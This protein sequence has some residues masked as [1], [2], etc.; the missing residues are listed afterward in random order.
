ML[1]SLAYGYKGCSHKFK[2]AP[3]EKFF[4]NN[5]QARNV[6]KAGGKVVKLIGYEFREERRWAKAKLEDDKYLY[7]FPLVEWEWSR[8]ECIAAINRMGIPL[9]GKSSCFFCPASTK[10]EIDQLK[11]QYPVLFQRALSLEDNAK[12]NLTSVKGLGRR[13]SWRDYATTSEV[14]DV[15]PCMSC[16][17]GDGCDIKT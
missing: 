4:N 3:Q 15:I 2:I 11:T 6:W 14:P 1:P 16:N 10:P 8:P 13:F 5:S 7:R 9:P 17:D 12:E